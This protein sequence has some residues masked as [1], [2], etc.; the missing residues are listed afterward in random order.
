MVTVDDTVQEIYREL[1]QVSDTQQLLTQLS[2]LGREAQG[3]M[4]SWSSYRYSD[5]R[6]LRADSV[7]RFCEAQR[8]YA[9]VA[10]RVAAQSDDDSAK[11]KLLEIA[12]EYQ[13]MARAAPE[14]TLEL[15]PVMMDAQDLLDR[16][17]SCLKGFASKMNEAQSS[18]ATYANPPP[19]HPKQ[20]SLV[21][22]CIAQEEVQRCAAELA[23]LNGLY[24]VSQSL[25]Q[26]SG[27]YSA[28]GMSLCHR[29]SAVAIA[30]ISH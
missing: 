25:S 17:T 6:R 28:L 7:R 26:I 10:A 27:V 2:G 9:I 4:G 30:E 11:G 29:I 14:L 13:L 18:L 20:V 15:S 5:S 19:S 12:E 3:Y 22:F 8:D 1:M 16:T 23:G 21:S 24:H